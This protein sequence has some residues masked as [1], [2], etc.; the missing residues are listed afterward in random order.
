MS[1]VQKLV[2]NQPAPRLRFRQITSFANA[3]QR[4]EVARFAKE[5][6]P[7]QQTF[8]SLSSTKRR[9]KN[10]NYQYLTHQIH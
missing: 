5:A 10:D 9:I 7:A 4:R 6:L 8:P 2:G 1:I 3:G